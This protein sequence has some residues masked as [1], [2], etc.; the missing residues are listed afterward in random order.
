M[1]ISFGYLGRVILAV[2][3]NWPEVVW[4]LVKASSVRRK[5]KKIL[6]R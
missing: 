4:N 1:V 3:D 6:I 5:M 2:D